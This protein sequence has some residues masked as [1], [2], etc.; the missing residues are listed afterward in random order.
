MCYASKCT[1][2]CVNTI[3]PLQ[4]LLQIGSEG[5]VAARWYE[6]GRAVG[7]DRQILE[8]CANYPPEEAIVEIFEWW[9]K[10]HQVTWKDVSEVLNNVGFQ[11]LATCILK[12]GKCLY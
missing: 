12:S 2:D 4:L 5:E 1:I 10:N 9:A 8:E 6:L 11:K 7:I 3:V